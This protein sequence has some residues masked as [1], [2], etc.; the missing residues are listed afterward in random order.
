MRSKNCATVQAETRHFWKESRRL[1]AAILARDEAEK[2]EALDEL[3]LLARYTTSSILCH[4]AKREI[5]RTLE[6]GALKLR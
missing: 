2:A 6:A 4:R 5:S 3:D 1:R